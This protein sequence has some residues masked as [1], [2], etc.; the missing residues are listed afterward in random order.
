MDMATGAPRPVPV[1][2]EGAWE[3]TGMPL[4]ALEAAFGQFGRQFQEVV[5]VLFN[6]SLG[7][8]NAPEETSTGT[9]PRTL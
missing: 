6:G 9:K 2:E 4:S 3:A 5:N 1:L 7:G 8:N